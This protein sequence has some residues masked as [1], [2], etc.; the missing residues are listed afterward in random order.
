MM[1]KILT[2][3]PNIGRTQTCHATIYD[4]TT[5]SSIFSWTF[6]NYGNL[7]INFSNF[8][9]ESIAQGILTISLYEST[10]ECPNIYYPFHYIRNKTYKEQYEGKASNYSFTLIWSSTNHSHE[11]MQAYQDLVISEQSAASYFI[12]YMYNKKDLVFSGIILPLII[13]ILAT[14]LSLF[15]GKLIQVARPES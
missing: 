9:N 12:A 15:I 1:F 6:T 13:L 5:L 11:C 14:I 7:T 3:L 8:H 10:K 2:R 4:L